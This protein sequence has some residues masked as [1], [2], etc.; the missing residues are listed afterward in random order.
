[1][2]AVYFYSAGTRDVYMIDIYSKVQKADLTAR[3][4]REIK[5]LTDEI[6][7]WTRK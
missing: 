4:K 7:K 2:R 1:M 6:K 3:D 5:A